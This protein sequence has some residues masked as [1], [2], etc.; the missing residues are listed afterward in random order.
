[1]ESKLKYMGMAGYSADFSDV[2][3]IDTSNLNFGGV[4]VGSQPTIDFGGS[5]VPSVG[6][7]PNWW[8][9]N[10]N[11]VTGGVEALKGLALTTAQVM[12]LIQTD[13][14]VVIQQPGQPPKDY[15]PQLKQVYQEKGEAGINQLMMMMLAK[16]NQTPPKEDKTLLYVGLGFGGLLL[17]GGMMYMMKN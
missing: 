8:Q 13:K 11:I 17:L 12:R 5:N 10:G 16:Q 4:N 3:N 1:M 2:G 7:Q 14:P 15:T 6:S 9:R